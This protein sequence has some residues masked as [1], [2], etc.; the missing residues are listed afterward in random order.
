V[1]VTAVDDPVDETP[2]VQPAKVTLATSS[3]DAGYQGLAGAVA[4]SATDNDV[5]GYEVAAGAAPSVT[6]GAAS[7]NEV[8]RV[9]LTSRPTA[10]VT[11]AIGGSAD[12]R[13]SESSLTFAPAAWDSW[14]PVTIAAID[15]TIAE[16]SPQAS[17]VG[18]AATST[19]PAFASLAAKTLAISVRDDDP[20]RLT[21]AAGA[22]WTE[23]SD[24]D[25]RLAESGEPT[26]RLSVRAVGDPTRDIVITPI[27]GDDIAVSP[28]YQKLEGGSHATPVAFTFHAVDD[29]VAEQAIEA[30]RIVWRITTNDP[31][32][33]TATIAPIGVAIADGAATTPQGGG[34]DGG[35]SSTPTGANPQPDPTPTDPTPATPN[36]TPDATQPDGTT[37]GD[38]GSGAGDDG[39]SDDSAARRATPAAGTNKPRPHG[40]V[41]RRVKDWA[42]DHPVAASAAGSA[43]GTALLAAKPLALAGK[44]LAGHGFNMPNGIDELRKVF[45]KKQKKPHML[46]RL[47]KKRRRR[48]DEDEDEWGDDDFDLFDFWSGDDR[49]A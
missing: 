21:T 44:G 26:A 31:L 17:K 12:L 22:G 13:A 7:T 38:D 16:A 10:G 36:P 14:Q 35:G 15:D 45:R 42:K 28:A 2:D 49:A 46:R 25:L 9:R 39:T 27:V 41:T 20:A 33:D 6:E 29:H 11:I 47:F 3:A 8:V 18:F 23:T 24:G 4:A 48:D 1:T 32:Y 43:A 19:D 40:P 30:S 34:S 37:V 5:A